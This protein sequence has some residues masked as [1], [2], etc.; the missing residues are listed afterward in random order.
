MANFTA[1]ETVLKIRQLYDGGRGWSQGRLAREFRLS[2][3]TI[4]KMVTYQT[5]NKVA[6]VTNDTPVPM[7]AA[8]AVAESARRM[9]AQQQLLDS[10]AQPLK[11]LDIDQLLAE[12]KGPI[13]PE[14]ALQ[15]DEIWDNSLERI[16]KRTPYD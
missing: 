15:A 7:A 5:Y 9:L 11:S 6:I 3:G 10:N 2:R 4:Q 14:R 8:D 13:G 1:A 16:R 12:A